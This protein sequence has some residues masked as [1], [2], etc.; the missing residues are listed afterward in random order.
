MN[1]GGWEKKR[2]TTML[3][4]SFPL[5]ASHLYEEEGGY[6]KAG[7]HGAKLYAT[8]GRR[9]SYEEGKTYS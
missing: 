7:S 6:R 3:R 8:P 2:K 1:T 5:F 9:D 4:S